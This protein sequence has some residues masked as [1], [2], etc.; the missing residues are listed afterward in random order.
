MADAELPA[1]DA[2]IEALLRDRR[3]GPPDPN[4]MS[5]WDFALHWPDSALRARVWPIISRLLTDDDELVRARAAEF[6]RL[7]R[8][9]A[10]LTTE[11]LISVGETYGELYGD[12]RPEGITLRC[13]LA[14]ALAERAVSREQ[15][16]IARVLEYLG[17]SG[18][19]GGGAASVLGEF[20]P[21]FV[22]AQ[23]AAWGDDAIESLEPAAR[24]LAAYRRD[25]IV[26]FL[27]AARGLSRENRERLVA[28]VDGA[29]KRD[30]G[31]AAAI[32]KVEGL[33]APTKPAPSTAECRRA[34]GL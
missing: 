34:I 14:S 29:V 13:E 8:D 16:R 3:F 30:D 33:P 27:T 5:P 31:K 24:S 28:V 18:P 25:E 32:A 11:R 17:S 20:A 7:W 9:G 6:V 2:A 21:D 12:Q 23:V 26:P 10:D 19:V 15:R 1:N 22:I 4:E